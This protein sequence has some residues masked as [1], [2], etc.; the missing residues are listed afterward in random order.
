MDETNKDS[1]CNRSVLVVDDDPSAIQLIHRAIPQY[2]DIRFAT[3]GSDAHRLIRERIPD[4]LLLDA[5]MP[6]ETG[7]ELCRR[8]K[9]DSEFAQIS[10]IFITS[11]DG[12]DFE[13]QA[14]EAGAADFIAKPIGGLRVRLR[15]DL[16][17]RLK[18]QLDELRTLAS[19]DGLTRLAN[20]RT[21]DETLV[22]EWSRAQRNDSDVSLLLID[23][24][25]FK[26]FNDSYGHP[27]GDRC[28][29]EVARIVGTI[30]Q[31]PAD[32]AGRFGGEEFA[33]ILPDTDVPGALYVANAV[34]RA[35]SER[36][37]P[38]RASPVAPN[39]TIS[40]GVSC[41]DSRPP[42]SPKSELRVQPRDLLSAADQALYRA[43]ERGRDCVEFLPISN[44]ASDSA[45]S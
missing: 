31:R 19:T 43:K 36:N 1:L 29:Q 41:W 27:A 15:V 6:G 7:F 2:R 39:V 13:A 16:H 26:L 37:I 33:L 25:H 8:L 21:I 18:Q 32:L 11:Y 40:V 24:D 17:M 34:R 28:L 5:E 45:S 12:L 22:R 4:V 35:V 23:V 14:I 3:N 44:S 10:I 30:G 42:P 20:R 38:H 9:A